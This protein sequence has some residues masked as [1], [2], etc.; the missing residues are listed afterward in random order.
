MT[1][2]PGK[3]RRL[4]QTLA[5]AYFLLLCWLLFWPRPFEFLSDGP[6]NVSEQIE[7]TFAD[8][9]LHAL[10]FLLLSALVM[11]AQ[12]EKS[13]SV[14]K[15]TAVRFLAAF[16][17]F[18]ETTHLWIPERFFQWSDMAANL[19]GTAAGILVVRVCQRSG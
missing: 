17:L 8:W 14:F 2:S 18:A 19:I 10:A 16:S 3:S 1:Y 5:L 4:L 7:R 11:T 13:R 9:V 6:R 15:S 12:S